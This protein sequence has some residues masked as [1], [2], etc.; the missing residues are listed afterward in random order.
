MDWVLAEELLRF[1]LEL[2]VKVFGVVGVVFF[3]I[4]VWQVI[5]LELGELLP[6]FLTY[7]FASLAF[8]EPAIVSY[9]RV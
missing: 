8:D 5:K 3:V 7:W 4:V 2:G 9:G 1:E 6:F